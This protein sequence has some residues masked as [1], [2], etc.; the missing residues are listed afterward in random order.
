LRQRHRDAAD[1]DTIDSLAAAQG[2][3]SQWKVRQPM[4]ARMLHCS[5]Q[6]LWV[7]SDATCETKSLEVLAADKEI[8][9][10]RAFYLTSMGRVSIWW[11]L[12]TGVEEGA[13]TCKRFPSSSLR[14]LCA[15]LRS[16][17][18]H[19]SWYKGSTRARGRFCERKL[20][21][22][23]CRCATVAQVPS[24]RWEWVRR[25][26]RKSVAEQNDRIM[27]RMSR[28]MQDNAG[29]ALTGRAIIAF[30]A[31]KIDLQVP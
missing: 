26:T 14:K 6:M 11:W 17:S 25:S 20:R 30:V 1:S 28:S 16:A 9:Q 4:I 31:N 27:W 12:V 7:K 29:S 2:Q 13:V 3:I 8:S 10:P 15:S 22:K 18:T 5:T 23:D 21:C 19:A 24:R